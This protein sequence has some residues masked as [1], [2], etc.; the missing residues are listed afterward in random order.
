VTAGLAGLPTDIVDIELT[1]PLPSV[2]PRPGQDQVRVLGR[3]HSYPVGL[4]SITVPPGG[5]TPDQL[6]AGVSGLLPALQRHLAT[7]GL[8]VPRELRPE[9]KAGVGRPACLARRDRAL[10]EAPAI[11]VLIATRDRPQSLL[12]VLASVARCRHPRTDVLV[13]DNAPASEATA[14]VVASLGGRVGAV[15]VRYV[16]EPQPG[17][18]AARNR[19]LREISGS[20]VAITDDDCLVDAEWLAGIA[21][22]AAAMPGVGCVT[23]PT[24]P[25]ELATP[26][27]RL[28]ERAGGFAQGFTRRAWDFGPHRPPGEP[29]F[30]VAAGTFGTG[31]N[32]AF[33][34]AVL[35]ELGGFDPALGAGVASRGG[36]DLLALLQV[37]TAGYTISYEPAALVAHR[38]PR[39]H[40]SLRRQTF[41]YGAGLGAYLTSA[42]VRE[43]RLLASMLGKSVPAVRYLLD[44]ASTKNRAKQRGFPLRL[45]L[46]ELAGLAQGPA[47]YGLSRWRDRRAR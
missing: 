5:L 25:A 38:H 2:S 45:E 31:A 43:P 6:A 30:P 20:W 34:V 36:E 32:M 18:S 42:A 44:P 15:P 28:R 12:R 1:G 40:A 22:A 41:D 3:A 37:I 13:V 8:P 35:D 47:R 33:D 9:Q 29:L 46:T 24:V 4:L 17:V 7:E 27:Q 23:G 10:A 19:G 21:E 14:E 11:T 16:R 39:D 26:A